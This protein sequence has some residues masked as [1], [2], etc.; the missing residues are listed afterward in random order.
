MN[1]RLDDLLGVA[2]ARGE[3][4]GVA[5][6]VV[7][8]DQTLYSGAFGERELGS[9]R[10]MAINS[11]AAVASMTKA[12]T[13]TA[14]L[15]L[16]EQGRLSLDAPA[17]EV[18]PYLGEAQ[19]LSGFDSRGQ[20]ILREPRT[21][22][23]LRHLLTH[24]AG[25]GYEM[26]NEE[27]KRYDAVTGAI[28]SRSRTLA[29]FRKPLLFDPGDRWNYGINTDW[30]GMMVEA[31][32]GQRLGHYLTEHVLT[33]LGMTS[34][35]YRP[36]GELAC[37]MATLH[38]RC[39]DGSLTIGKAMPPGEVDSGGGGLYSTVAD[40]SRFCQMV[41]NQG[42]LSGQ[43]ILSPASVAELARDQ[44]G[45]KGVVALRTAMPELSNDAE[46]F[47][48]VPKG[49]SL[50]FLINLEQAPTGRSAGSMSWAGLTNCYQWIDPVRDIAGVY[51][52]QVLPFFD[53]H[54]WSLY[55]EFEKAVYENF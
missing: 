15:Q 12:V 18:A 55:L 3:V 10:E 49:W 41:L 34:T 2:V 51:I 1:K 25:F 29:G 38:H 36:G 32:S 37:R 43:R 14:V 27:I 42:T 40:Y 8:G 28:S 6:M 39:E 46:F 11:V 7:R 44:L 19:V 22:I 31:V 17:A 45:G 13:C 20:P 21:P 53:R 23:T 16:V 4:P 47:P 5:A 30:A 33:P 24:S 35:T 54:S 9:G 50:G 26:W 52:T 48:A